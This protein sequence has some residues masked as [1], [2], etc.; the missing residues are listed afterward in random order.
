MKIKLT[1]TDKQ[2]FHI[3]M[4]LNLYSRIN[5]GQLET[6]QEAIGPNRPEK[7]KIPWVGT[8]IKQIEELKKLNFPE[9]QP[10]ESYGISQKEAPEVC[11]EMIDIHDTI[12][13]FLAWK[14]NPEGGYTVNFNKPKNYSKDDLPLIEEETE[15]GSCE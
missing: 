11:R 5:L 2:A 6:I 10:N 15:A 3:M 9:L 13:H 4:A 7:Y 12:R 8:Y 1:I 14:E